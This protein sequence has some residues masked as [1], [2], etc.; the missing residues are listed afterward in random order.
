MVGL[1]DSRI[2]VAQLIRSDIL[3]SRKAVTD[4]GLLLIP[5]FIRFTA[6]A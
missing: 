6:T 4:A 5:Y 3:L 2:V 1:D